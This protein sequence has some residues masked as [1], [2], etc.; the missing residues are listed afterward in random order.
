VIHYP[1]HGPTDKPFVVFMVPAES[2][3]EYA[4]I[5]NR[6]TKTVLDDLSWDHDSVEL[7]GLTSSSV[8]HGTEGIFFLEDM[9]IDTRGITLL[10]LWGE[11]AESVGMHH[12]VSEECG[13]AAVILT[14]TGVILP[15][16][17][18]P[19]LEDGWWADPLHQ[20]YAA[21]VFTGLLRDGR[22]ILNE[23]APSIFV[24]GR[25]AWN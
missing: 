7:I 12:L 6:L 17:A 14:E 25:H 22:A 10:M 20:D 8:K 2:A 13:I 15:T 9:G 1:H 21:T 19:R 11:T 24:T 18:M 16:V 3:T 23:D 4:F 5:M